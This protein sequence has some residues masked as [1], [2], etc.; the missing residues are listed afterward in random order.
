MS[1][2]LG[3]QIRILCGTSYVLM[4]FSGPPINKVQLYYVLRKFALTRSRIE[5]IIIL[6]RV[7][8]FNSLILNSHS[9]NYEKNNEIS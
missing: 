4:T 2:G 7:I 1:S 5:R 3:K 6:I 8:L 9:V